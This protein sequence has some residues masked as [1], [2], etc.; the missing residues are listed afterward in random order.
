MKRYTLKHRDGGGHRP[1]FAEYRNFCL[2]LA[3]EADPPSAEQAYGL[4]T[5][6][7]RHPKAPHPDASPARL[8]ASFSA[9]HPAT[10]EAYTDARFFG[11]LEDRDWFCPF[12]SARFHESLRIRLLPP[13]KT[14]DLISK[15]N[16]PFVPDHPPWI[17]DILDMDAE[18]PAAIAYDAPPQILFPGRCF[19]FSGG[20]EYG[21]RSKCRAAAV[22]RGGKWQGNISRAVDVLVVAG[23]PDSVTSFSSKILGWADFRS[24][25]HH[26]LLISEAQWLASL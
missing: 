3:I 21:P 10:K 22:E 7:R 4:F 26:C 19:L 25:G 8:A 20:F 13:R 23:Q 15:Y 17:T 2:S 5:L 24:T 11:E 6:L 1:F 9:S 14:A 18:P 12:W 16:I